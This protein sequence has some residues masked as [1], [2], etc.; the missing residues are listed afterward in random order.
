MATA[1]TAITEP[2]L[3]PDLPTPTPDRFG[4]AAFDGQMQAWLA[5]FPG[6]TSG[7][8]E[9]ATWLRSTAELAE[10]AAAA[11]ST[12][13]GNAATTA[14][15][16]GEATSEAAAAVQT[17]KT[18]AVDA[19][20][21]AVAKAAI[22][23]DK[24]ALAEGQATT[25]TTQSAAAAAAKV[26]AELAR[27]AALIQGGVYVDEPTGRAAVA[28]GV[29]FKVQGSGDVAAYEYRRVNS[30]GSVLIAAYPSIGQLNS[31][32]PINARRRGW[33]HVLRSAGGKLGL[34]IDRYGRVI[35]GVGGDIVARIAATE[36]FNESNAASILAT[37]A[38]L[39]SGRRGSAV[40][41]LLDS[42]GTKVALLVSRTGKLISMGRDV[43]GEIDAL[44]GRVDAIVAN[45]SKYLSPNKDLT[46]LGDSQLN[47]AGPTPWRTLIVPMI[48]ARNY[49]NLAVGGQTSTHIAGRFG[50]I[51][52]LLTVAGNSIPASGPV[53]VTACRVLKTDGTL[54]NGFTPITNQGSNT[55]YG[56]L[57]GVLGTWTRA[58]GDGSYT[59]TRAVDGTAVGC[60]EGTP[61]KPVWADYDLNTL[62]IGLGRNNLG[63]LPTI[64][65]DVEACSAAQRSIEKRQIILTVTNGG[66]ITPG[67]PT[68]EGVGTTTGNNVVALELWAESR[69]TG[70]G[71]EVVNVR[72]LLMQHGDGSTDDNADIAAGTVPRSLRIDAV[73]YSAAA[74]LLIA[75][76][77]ASII[78]KKGW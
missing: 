50:A 8:N 2:P 68:N 7:A 60:P 28:D 44:D 55:L 11:A 36:A 46:L 61:F 48:S 13:A 45:P 10:A 64:K 22:A 3:I 43:L 63:D 1:S 26:A 37:K 52:P 38:V 51:A 40:F 74:H 29:A 75:E 24:A 6:W 54:D 71:F 59:F 15:G 53:T 18:D 65:R 17:A 49:R 67:V 41:R 27:D 42:T 19:A 14:D 20:A 34:G 31:R 4:G 76:H 39:K 69:F 66:S 72:K 35:L 70:P 23:T 77:I 16:I 57:A 9:L 62:V 73:H 33:V 47:G 25:A 5:S 56:S 12:S 78:N 32:T 58:A 30:A 21:V